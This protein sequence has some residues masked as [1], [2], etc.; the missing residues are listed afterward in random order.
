MKKVTKPKWQAV[1]HQANPKIIRDDQYQAQIKSLS[2]LLYAH[3]A[4][5]KTNTLPTPP[6]K[7]FEDNLEPNPTKQEAA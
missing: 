5:P 6:T 3:F 7:P 1:S 4:N 2:Q